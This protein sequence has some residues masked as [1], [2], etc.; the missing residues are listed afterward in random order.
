MHVD[1]GLLSA[2]VSIAKRERNGI[3]NAIQPDV[4]NG[5][6]IHRNGGDA[7][8]RAS[9]TRVQSRNDTVEYCI[10]I[11]AQSLRRRDRSVRK[12]MNEVDFGL[13]SMPTEQ[14]YAAALGTQINRYESFLVSR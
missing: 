10:D 1:F 6:S 12:T 7:F 9:G 14:R 8:G 11:P 4:I 3:A 2:G 5:P 13:I